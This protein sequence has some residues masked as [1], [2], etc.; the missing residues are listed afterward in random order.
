L[1][2]D[3]RKT[4]SLAKCKMLV[5]GD[6]L[7][8]IIKPA[9]KR[10]WEVASS[11]LGLKPSVGKCY[12]SDAFVEM[13][14]MMYEYTPPVEQMDPDTQE[15]ITTAPY[16]EMNPSTEQMT[17]LYFRRVRYINLGLL[18]AVKKSQT[19]DKSNTKGEEEKFKSWGA[20]YRDLLGVSA[21]RDHVNLHNYFTTMHRKEL[22]RYNL[23]WYVPEWLGGYGM[24]GVHE[25][26]VLDL[27]VINKMKMNLGQGSGK[28]IADILTV[29]A[30]P[31]WKIH[32]IIMD[33][34]PGKLTHH[35][36]EEGKIAYDKLYAS[37]ALES[38]FT[39]S[40]TELFDPEAESMEKTML[41]QNER[42]WQDVLKKGHLPEPCSVWPKVIVEGNED[43]I[44]NLKLHVDDGIY[45]VKSFVFL[46]V[47]EQHH[48]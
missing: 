3:N 21:K 33:R 12:Y 45:K 43:D 42:V 27:R 9:G 47:R 37:L 36:T 46:D 14:S 22:N 23:P 31:N 16:K 28:S 25:P 20:I 13:N 1:E 39:S 40:L 48:R 24:I 8:A 34:L 2:F 38:L 19:G 41:K 5:N 44:D 7:G 11:T 29:S 26:S 35:E 4:I 18:F 15:V 30:T 6:D 17:Q 32:K 10:F